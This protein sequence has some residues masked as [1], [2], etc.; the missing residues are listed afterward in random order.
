[1]KKKTKPVRLSARDANL[2]RRLRRHLKSIGFS[3]GPDGG[4]VING[5]GKDVIRALHR[6]QRNA[7]LRE[8]RAFIT[9]QLPKLQKYFASGSEIDLT[10]IK[11]ELELIESGKWQSALFRLA[12]ALLILRLCLSLNQIRA[13]R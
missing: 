5:A 2:K 9:E 13:Y 1:M 10:R 7:I 4:L 11:P 6:A 8:N 12:A 3:K